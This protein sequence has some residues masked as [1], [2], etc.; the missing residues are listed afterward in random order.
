MAL[1]DS[2]SMFK[3]GEF[4]FLNKDKKNAEKT[5]K[6]KMHPRPQIKVEEDDNASKL[7]SSPQA[8]EE[9]EVSE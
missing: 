7:V 4:T 1:Y 3:E 8:S 9:K 2:T 5:T 6:L